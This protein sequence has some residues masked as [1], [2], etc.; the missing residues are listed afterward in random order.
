MATGIY[1]LTRPTETPSEAQTTSESR[2]LLD[3]T[4]SNFLLLSSLVSTLVAFLK[5]FGNFGY[6][7]SMRAHDHI[8]LH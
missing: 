1:I 7:S 4:E 8:I 2:N 3:S 6:K 5:I